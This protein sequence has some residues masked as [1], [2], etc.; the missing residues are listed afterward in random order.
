MDFSIPKTSPDQVSEYL[1]SLKTPSLDDEIF[2][3]LSD[4]YAKI[5]ILGGLGFIGKNFYEYIVSKDLFSSIII[6]D[7]SLPEISHLPR[8]KLPIYRQNKKTQFVQIDLCNEKDL[9]KVFIDNP[10][11]DIV[12]NLASETRLSLSDED[13]FHRCFKMPLLCGKLAAEFKVK[14]FIQMSCCKIYKSASSGKIKENYATEP[15]DVRYM[16]IN[17]AERELKKMDGLNLVILRAAIVY[18]PYDFYG[19]MILRISGALIYKAL[20]EKMRVMWDGGLKTNTVNVYD[21]SRAL[22]YSI[23]KC[24]KGDIFNL[25]D[26]NDSDQNKIHQILREV[27]K[28]QIECVG[29][30]RSYLMRFSLDGVIQILNEK[31]LQMW[32]ELCAKYNMLNSPVNVVVYRENLTNNVLFI[33][34]EAF[35]QQTGFKYMIPGFETKYFKAL[36]GDYIKNG[37]LPPIIE[38]FENFQN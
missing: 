6:V 24:N 29:S 18:G 2:K 8:D 27:F 33:E 31:H 14:K 21:L 19:E 16:N 22:I 10:D 12:V 25:V 15:W 20:G 9:R 34:G 17:E 5:L 32:F 3:I 13:Y 36:I 38:N 1:I 23:A 4:K 35:K 37:L 7:K 11:I 28:I 30:V 26:D